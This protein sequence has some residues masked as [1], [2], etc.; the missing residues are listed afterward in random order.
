MELDATVIP[1][2][3]REYRPL[4]MNRAGSKTWAKES[5][6]PPQI[7]FVFQHY[8]QHRLNPAQSLHD[9][10]NAQLKQRRDKSGIVSD[11]NSARLTLDRMRIPRTDSLADL[12]ANALN[13]W[14]EMSDSEA[15]PGKRG[16]IDVNF[17][18]C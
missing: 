1:I 14:V 6:K 11:N 8:D 15:L 18:A 13:C 16:E 12:V 9:L 2:R 7:Q 5:P 3:I 17:D 4:V 10:K